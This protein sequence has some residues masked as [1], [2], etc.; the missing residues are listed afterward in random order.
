MGAGDPPLFLRTQAASPPAPI[1]GTHSFELHP[2][3]FTSPSSPPSLFQII[4]KVVRQIESSGA[5]DTQEREEVI[6]EGPP[7]DPGEVPVDIDDFMKHIKVPWGPQPPRPS[8]FRAARRLYLLLAS[9][10][11]TP[12][13]GLRCAHL[14]GFPFRPSSPWKAADT[15]SLLL[16]TCCLPVCAICPV[17]C[18]CCCPQVERRGNS[19]QPDLIE[20]RKGA[21]I[22]KRASLKRGK[23]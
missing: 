3:G 14:S 1:P 11:G 10:P 9:V 21:Q 2:E 18:L 13:S 5:D 22:V 15:P 19:L 20:G 17:F 7:E 6:V 12:G 16:P 8:L 4:R 23:Q